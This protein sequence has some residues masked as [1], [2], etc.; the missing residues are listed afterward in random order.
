VT[1]I[2]LIQFAS[3]QAEV[4]F[5][6]T[7]Q[8]FPMWHAIKSNGEQLILNSPSEDKDLAV[9][10]VKAAF[11][12]EDVVTYVFISEVWMLS[13]T[14]DRDRIPNSL[15]D[16]P[17]RREGIFFA[18]EDNRGGEQTAHRFILRPEHGKP[19]LTPLVMDDMAGLTSSGRMV[20]LLRRIQ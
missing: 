9:A 20:G 2:D 19:K 7:G 6:R 15:S 4:I 10:M 17:D 5:R 11:E 13:T 1:L 3:A 16:H 12:L 14:E 18:A 8:I